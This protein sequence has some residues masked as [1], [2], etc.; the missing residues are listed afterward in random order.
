MT[1][2]LTDRKLNINFEKIRKYSKLS[3]VCDIINLV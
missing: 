1:M 2:K 3:K